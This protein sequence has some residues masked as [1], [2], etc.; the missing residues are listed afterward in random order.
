M[1]EGAPPTL[2]LHG[3]RD[4]TVPFKQATDFCSAMKK[5][6]NA[7]KVAAYEGKG[8]A[9]FNYGKNNNKDF[10]ETTVDVHE[11]LV[12]IGYLKGKATVDKCVMK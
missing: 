10:I 9:W 2:I 12:S 6:G 3:T 11:F 1:R 7:C 8:H 4:K 5:A